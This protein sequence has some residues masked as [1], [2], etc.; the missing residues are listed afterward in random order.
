M[1]SCSRFGCGGSKRRRK[2][3][4]PFFCSNTRLN[5]SLLDCCIR[6]STSLGWSCR[7][8][9]PIPSRKVCI[10][11]RIGPLSAVIWS[12]PMSTGDEMNSPPLQPKPLS[13]VPPYLL[14]GP[15]PLSDRPKASRAQERENL[16]S[17]I[18]ST[19]GRRSTIDLG[20]TQN[21]P[22]TAQGTSWTGLVEGPTSTARR[23]PGTIHEPARDV[24]DEAPPTPPTTASRPASPY[25]L[26]PPI[27][28]D[29]LSWPCQPSLP[30]SAEPRLMT[31]Q[32]SEPANV[33][34]KPPKRH[35]HGWTSS[36]A[37]SGPFSSALAKTPSAKACAR[38][39]NDM[40]RR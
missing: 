16:S 28:F 14:N 13:A 17:S 22:S 33:L 20:D 6:L 21:S 27:D 38:L 29:G 12:L 35:R 37:L 39:R 10:Y 1:S 8:L 32:V 15:S 9:L 24:R 25:T 7:I 23:R 40:L 18:K 2:L 5:T 30:I 11:S 34:S 31:R 36:P 26:N 4:P 3:N 19:Y